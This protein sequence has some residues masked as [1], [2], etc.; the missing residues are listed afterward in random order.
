MEAARMIPPPREVP[1][2]FGDEP[3]RPGPGQS[4]LF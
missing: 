4:G 3:P 1:V 2:E